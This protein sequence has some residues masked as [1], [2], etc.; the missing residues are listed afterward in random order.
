MNM[1]DQSDLGHV[2]LCRSVSSVA[3]T[4]QP[5]ESITSPNLLSWEPWAKK[6]RPRL[7]LKVCPSPPFQTA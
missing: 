4:N 6:V 7:L 2:F 1:G 5:A 3:L